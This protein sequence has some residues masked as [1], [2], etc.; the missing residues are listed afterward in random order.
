M[1]TRHA[2]E[3]CTPRTP[4]S[5]LPASTR[6]DLSKRSA[7][8]HI[9]ERK[10][11]PRNCFEREPVRH[12]SLGPWCAPTAQ[13]RRSPVSKAWDLAPRSVRRRC[14]DDPQTAGNLVL[15]HA[16]DIIGIADGR[17]HRSTQT[18]RCRKEREYRKGSFFY[19]LCRRWKSTQRTAAR[20]VNHVLSWNGA[21]VQGMDVLRSDL[22]VVSPSH[23]SFLCHR[24]APEQPNCEEAA[25]HEVLFLGGQGPAASPSVRPS[26]S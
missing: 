5:P 15:F 17:A 20:S 24:E 14:C 4:S 11:P 26:S 16:P 21:T 13:S 8:K 7:G 10:L 2:D 18:R 23:P 1:Q 9:L 22:L 6:T 3:L 25:N 12:P 19:A